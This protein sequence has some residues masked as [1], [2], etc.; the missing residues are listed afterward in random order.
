MTDKQHGHKASEI[1]AERVR[2]QFGPEVRNSL[3]RLEEVTRGNP[4]FDS[5]VFALL[6]G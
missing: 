2:I 6:E 5:N 4:D 3:T 1:A